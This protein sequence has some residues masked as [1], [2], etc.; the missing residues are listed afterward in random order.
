MARKVIDCRVMPSESHCSLT[1]TGEED[2]VVR[3][4]AEH[5]VSV[6]GHADTAEL[7]DG[8]RSGLADETSHYGTVMIGKRKVSMDTLH[9]AS[10]EWNRAR[11]VPGFLREDAM[12]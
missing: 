2:E 4:A 10:E 8:I 3:A 11:R 6:H 5:A 12:D 1:I 7:R 9:Q